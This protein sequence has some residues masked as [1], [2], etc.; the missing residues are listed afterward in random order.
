[1]GKRICCLL[2]VIFTLAACGKAEIDSFT[3]IHGLEYSHHDESL[4][5]AT[6]YG[7]VNIADGG[8]THVGGASEQHDL[9]G[10]SIIDEEV[11]ISSG[12]PSHDSKLADPLGVM[13]SK[14]H[15]ETWEPIALYEEVDFHILH[16]NQSDRNIIYG[17]DAYHSKLYRSENGGYDWNE[18]K[19]EGLQSPVGSILSLTSHPQ[20]PDLLLA[21]TEDGLFQSENGGQLWE[22]TESEFS[23]SALKTIDAQ[24]ADVLAYLIGEQEGLFVS[25][26]FGETWLS[27]NFKLQGDYVTY[28]AID[29]DNDQRIALGSYNQS[30][31]ETNDFGKTWRT[32]S[33]LGQKANE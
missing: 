8:W 29:A 17:I 12:H 26:D 5:V 7:L 27:L 6:H 24:S 22:R 3:H 13:L 11:M 19:T 2:F 23:A 15:G 9:M 10:F 1:M 21:G 16:V 14:D 28:I 20:Q 32:I 4:F 30:I 18:V 31:M 33:E 25:V